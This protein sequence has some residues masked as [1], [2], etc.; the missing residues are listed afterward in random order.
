M[1]CSWFGLNEVDSSEIKYV[2]MITVYQNQLIIIR[3]K[4]RQLWELPGGKREQN[5]DLIQA[6][7]REL[8]EETGA[9][10]FELTP[11]GVYLMNESYGMIFFV[12][13]KELHELPDYEIEEI[14]LVKKLP[15]NLLYGLIYY[16]MYERC[17]D[18]DHCSLKTYEIDYRDLKL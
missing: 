10:Q 13:V 14:R 7:S 1:E 9:V 12:K 11:F 5:E 16:E 6:A 8:Y 3:N 17:E 15:E 2:V 18:I 4:Q